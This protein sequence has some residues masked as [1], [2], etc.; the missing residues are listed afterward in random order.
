[1]VNPLIKVSRIIRVDESAITGTGE[2]QLSAIEAVCVGDSLCQTQPIGV[3]G[4]AKTSSTVAGA[5]AGGNDATGGF[6][7][8]KVTDSGTGYGIGLYSEGRR[9]TDT[10]KAIG[11]EIRV[12][13]QT[14]TN[15]T[16]SSGGPATPPVCG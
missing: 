7:I 10:A 12:A 8:G 13:N 15:G 4:G 11:L 6:F 1:V 16:Y 14:A 3:F 5:T 2:D 9:D